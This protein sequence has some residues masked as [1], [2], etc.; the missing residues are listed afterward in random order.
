MRGWRLA[1]PTS[2]GA[3]LSEL[4]DSRSL[5]THCTVRYLVGAFKHLE[6]AAAALPDEPLLACHLA[7]LGVEKC[8]EAALASQGELA[9]GM[10]WLRRLAR[11]SNGT[12]PA[13]LTLRE[14][15]RVGE[16]LLFPRDASDA[17]AVA[18]HVRA[19]HSFFQ[20]TVAVVGRDVAMCI[21]IRSC[22]QLRLISIDLP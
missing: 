16:Q 22:P 10:K 21:A 5:E 12:E 6:D 18:G 8:F 9:V 7:R 2:S 15:R 11:A 19:L 1:G 4:R 14:L 20:Q 3:L 17:S 13:A